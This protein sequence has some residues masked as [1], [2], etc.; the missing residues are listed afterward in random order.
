[1]NDTRRRA[2]S[3]PASLLPTLLLLALVATGTA[4]TTSSSGDAPIVQM[5][6]TTTR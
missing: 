4:S 3:W 2:S 1:V 5:T 6:V